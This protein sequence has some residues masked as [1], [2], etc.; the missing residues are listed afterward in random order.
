MHEK[1]LFFFS[2]MV[3][4]YQ[5]YSGDGYWFKSSPL[6]PFT[7]L[8]IFLPSY[9]ELNDKAA[10]E[11]YFSLVTQGLKTL[12]FS[13]LKQRYQQANWQDPFVEIASGTT[14]RYS[15]PTP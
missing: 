11:G 6:G 7:W 14:I 12:D 10:F 1:R 8:L 9:L 2:P 3:T 4:Q 13:A 5:R 15:T